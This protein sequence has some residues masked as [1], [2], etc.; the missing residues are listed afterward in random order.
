MSYISADLR[1]LVAERAGDGCKY[2]RLHQQ[3]VYFPF[4]VDHII[5]EKHEGETV[6]ENLCFSCPD[7]NSFKGSD[8]AAIDRETGQVSLLYHPR[9][10]QWTDHFRLEGGFI[11][12][13][14][15]IGRVTVFMLK[16]NLADRV[17]QR[18][19]LAQI[20]HYPCLG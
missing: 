5:S 16:L 4:E 1:R 14:T 17:I 2:C 11:A 12:P 13:L 7:C 3:E 19:M 20:G 18:E 8:I 9:T 10:Q 15:P 6:S